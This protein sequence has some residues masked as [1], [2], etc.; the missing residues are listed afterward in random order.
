M[1]S[2]EHAADRPWGD[3]SAVLP[4]LW[5]ELG[6]CRPGSWDLAA[7]ER[8]SRISNP[9]TLADWAGSNGE[10]SGRKSPARWQGQDLQVASLEMG[11]AGA[12][13]ESALENGSR[14]TR[15]PP[16]NPKPHCPKEGGKKGIFF[17][18]RGSQGMNF[19]I[20][21]VLFRCTRLALTGR[22][23]GYGWCLGQVKAGRATG[24]ISA[25]GAILAAP[26][27]WP[28][29]ADS[30]FATSSSSLSYHWK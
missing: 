22:A 19:H 9:P 21:Y 25:L 29:P 13:R 16:S 23:G 10:V 11:T 20:T 15:K 7:R 3:S 2:W 5:L 4:G 14:P 8:F 24:I 30:Y 27:Y 1:K 28:A 6:C 17:F 12:T 26:N 18:Q